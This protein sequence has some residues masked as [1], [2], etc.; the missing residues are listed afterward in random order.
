M[1]IYPFNG[2]LFSNQKEGSIDTCCSRMNLE[3]ILLMKPVTY[4]NHIGFHL[5]ELCRLGK[6]R[7]QL[8]EWFRGWEEEGLVN[9]LIKGTG[10]NVLKLIVAMIAQLPEYAE[11]H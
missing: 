4:Y 9:Q 2:I 10:G 6:C 5:H 7:Q 8:V 11:N 3:N 1:M